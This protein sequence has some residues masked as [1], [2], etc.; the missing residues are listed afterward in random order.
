MLA[1]KQL[2][3]HKLEGVRC[4]DHRQPPRVQF[5]G[6]TLRD[7][8]IRMSGCCAKLADLANRAIAER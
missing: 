7:I 2:T 5:Q 3:Q 1:F 8:S 4:P 6:S